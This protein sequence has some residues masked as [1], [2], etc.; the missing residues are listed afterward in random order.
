MLS[1]LSFIII[2]MYHDQNSKILKLIVDLH[3]WIIFLWIL[4]Q[5]CRFNVFTYFVPPTLHVCHI[6]YIQYIHG[7]Y[8]NHFGGYTGYLA[9]RNPFEDK[10]SLSLVIYKLH[11]HRKSQAL[12]G[13]TAN[14]FH[15]SSRSTNTHKR[16]WSLFQEYLNPRTTC[17]CSLTICKYIW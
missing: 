10:L 11:K 14:L 4:F 7:L 8:K 15:I 12:T 13:K 2:I 1:F 16:L 9:Q 6:L 5:S 17:F 3:F